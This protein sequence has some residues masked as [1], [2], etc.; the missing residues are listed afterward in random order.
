MG[1]SWTPTVIGGA[2]AART[3][4]GS[5]A[6]CTAEVDAELLLIARYLGLVAMP[7]PVSIE[8]FVVGGD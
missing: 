3:D 4:S 8:V 6:Q 2:L 7:P 5:H 1:V